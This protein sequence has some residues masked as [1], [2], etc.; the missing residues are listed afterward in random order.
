M[1]PSTHQTIVT[2][3]VLV[4]GGAGYIGS[5]VVFALIERGIKVIALD[6]LTSGARHLV[7]PDALFVEG[8][9]GDIDMVGRVIRHHGCKTVMHFAGSII[10]PESFEVPLD[11]YHNNVSTSRN[12]IDAAV[13]NGIEAFIFSSS[14]AVYGAPDD[15]PVSEKATPAPISPYGRSKLMTEW[16]LADTA[17]AHGIRHACLRYFNVAGADQLGRAGQVG[18]ATHL[19]KIATEA[20]V[21]KRDGMQIFGDDYDTPDG[22]CIRDYVHVSDLA[23]AHVLALDYLLNGN[24]STAMNCSYGHGFSVHDVINAVERVA[25]VSLN[26]KIGPRRIG[27]PPALVGNGQRIK[28]EWGWSP[29]FD[30]LDVIIK[31]ALAWE[32]QQM[33]TGA[34]TEQS[35]GSSA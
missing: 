12:L 22:T 4:T 8:N 1:T 5:H 2:S 9:A 33:T 26:A 13:N 27:D 3:P 24:A 25:G 35:E 30:D 11:Y 34:V 21:G 15:I 16:M 29:K 23:D 7:N 14:A 28:S 10:N 18:P 20:A 17:T 19:I 31:T 32:R 6:N